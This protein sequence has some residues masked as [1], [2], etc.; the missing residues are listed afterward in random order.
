MT[1]NQTTQDAMMLIER[2]AALCATPGIDET[3]QGIANSQIQTLLHSIIKDAV[4]K[5]SAKGAGIM[6]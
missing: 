4:A 3:T 6:L 1:N 5:L 2:L